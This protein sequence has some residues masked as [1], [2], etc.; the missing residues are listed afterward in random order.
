MRASSV[1]IR[2]RAVLYSCM[3]A[4]IYAYAVYVRLRAHVI[5]AQT[6]AVLQGIAVEL[7][8]HH[9]HGVGTKYIKQVNLV[10]TQVHGYIK[11]V[12]RLACS[13]S[14]ILGLDMLYS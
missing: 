1:R 14:H 3:Y 6:R 12:G 5:G 7:H 8:R 13:T 10:G 11:Q 2:R 9:G 4:R